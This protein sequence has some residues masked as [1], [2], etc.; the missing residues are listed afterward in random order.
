MSSPNPT[1]PNVDLRE[2]TETMYQ[3]MRA[4]GGNMMKS[5][6]SDHSFS[7]TGLVGAAVERL[8]D[9][10]Q[11][12]FNDRSHLLAAAASAMRR[13]LVEHARARK[14]V[15]RGG[16]RARIAW[17]DVA[18]AVSTVDD[19]A[20]VISLNEVIE[21]LAKEDARSGAIVEMKAFAAMTD[22]EIARVLGVSVSTI[23]KDWRYLKPRVLSLLGEAQQ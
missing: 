10:D 7:P 3:S 21:K 12:R 13:V 17:D 22:V 5:E 14:R 18:N 16:D 19:P 1:P 4:I 6:R 2:L 11:A 23:E 9:N 15:K 8:L 20:L